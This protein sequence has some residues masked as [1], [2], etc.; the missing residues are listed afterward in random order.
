MQ[1][2][3]TFKLEKLYPGSPELGSTVIETFSTGGI[4]VGY[5]LSSTLSQANLIRYD[6]RY[7]EEYREFWKNIS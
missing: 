1:I 2:A 4:S 7:V 3:K 5:I 6:S